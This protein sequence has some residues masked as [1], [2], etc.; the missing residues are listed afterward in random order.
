[1]IWR[2]DVH[3]ILADQQIVSSQLLH[4]LLARPVPRYTSYPTAVEFT[5][6]VCP[7]DLAAGLLAARGDVSLYVHIPYCQQICWYCGCNTGVA[8]REQR[9]T[10]Y[11]EALDQEIGAVAGLLGAD[12]KVNRIAFGGGSPN[13]LAPLT[14][15]R[16]LDR[17]LTAFRSSAPV[18]SIELDPR[19][20]TP[21]WATTL[22]A[23]G[24]R[25][26]S[27]GVQTF[28]PDIQAAIGRIQPL[29]LVAQAMAALRTAGIG[30]INFDLMYGLP[31]QTEERFADTL[32]TAL[33][34]RPDR[35]AVFGYAH[36]PDVIPRQRRIDTT[37]L[38]SPQVRL[39]MADLAETSI[40]GAGY[41]EVGFDHFA[42]PGDPLAR[43]V[44]RG[45]LRRNFQGF[46]DD[47]AETLIGL[48]ASAISMF[49]DR[50]IQNAKNSGRYRS[51]LAAGL[52]PVE[53]GVLRD[54]DDR[55]RALAIEDF[56]CG[57]VA[58]LSA[59]EATAGIVEGFTPF[60]DAGLAEHDGYGVRYTAAGRR[61]ARVMAAQFD[62]YRSNPVR[63]SSS[64]V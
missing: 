21:E 44:A 42:L 25:N 19:G 61:Y 11:L 3:G 39:A 1:L 2:N 13:A 41:T 30:S 54:A 22:G 64:A 59:F 16:L 46:T 32:A 17:L 34:M 36:V 37:K 45:T 6:A 53:R 52:L 63:R 51:A 62:R 57:R 56:L 50:I 47:M 29:D 9:L 38:P 26:V 24:V 35:L 14:W 43:A 7:D 58:D 23:T 28:D 15:V 49:P 33:A 40:R 48:G 18:I 5:D 8:N 10:G 55:A 4:D 60:V 20:F 27:L 31:L 12:T